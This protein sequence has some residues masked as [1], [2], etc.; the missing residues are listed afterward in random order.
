MSTLQ[1]QTLEEAIREAGEGWLIDR[2]SSPAEAVTRLLRTLKDVGNLARERLGGE[3]P[4]F[5]ESAIVAEFQRRPA[6]VRGFFQALGGYRTPEMLLM[7][8]RV[9]QGMEIKRI[10]LSYERQQ[11]YELSVVL[12]TPCGDEE[13][14]RSTNASDFALLRH[15]GIMEVSGRPVFDGFYP[16]RVKGS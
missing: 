16:L 7:V 11:S 14:Y 13:P 9:I 1:A 8:W 12:E 15:I 3:A 2:S 5:S 6:Q 4:D 10:D